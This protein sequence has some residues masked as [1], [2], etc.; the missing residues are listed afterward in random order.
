MSYMLRR[1]KQG[2]VVI[3][4]AEDPSDAHEWGSVQADGLLP[5]FTRSGTRQAAFEWADRF[6][7]QTGGRIIRMNMRQ[8]RRLLASAS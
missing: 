3:R 6:V 2:D 4:R 5:A 8:Y 7:A 1:L